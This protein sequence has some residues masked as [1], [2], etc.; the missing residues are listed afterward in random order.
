MEETKNSKEVKN[1]LWYHIKMYLIGVAVYCGISLVIGLFF[2]QHF[3][4]FWISHNKAP[5]SEYTITGTDYDLETSSEI[6]NRGKSYTDETYTYYILLDINGKSYKVETNKKMY[7]RV[8]KEKP[9]HFDMSEAKFYY[10][11][12]RDKVFLGGYY[13]DA[14][15][16]FLLAFV[17]L[18]CIL[19]I[20]IPIAYRK[21]YFSD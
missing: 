13:S 5:L 1:S 11:S 18:F 15:Y 17:V 16:V 10:D 3:R 4:H 9:T 14:Y 20:Y 2:I 12:F 6:D 21:Q 8:Y 19:F 7:K